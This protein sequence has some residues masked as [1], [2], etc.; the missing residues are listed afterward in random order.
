MNECHEA[1]VLTVDGEM[2]QREIKRDSGTKEA[3][4]GCLL[5]FEMHMQSSSTQAATTNSK[6]SSSQ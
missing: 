4:S 1:D 6:C 3:P 5:D 2:H